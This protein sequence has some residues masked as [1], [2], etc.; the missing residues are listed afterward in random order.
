MRNHSDVLVVGGGVIGAACAYYL[1]REGKYVRIIEQDKIGSGASHGNCG[2]IF[3]SHLFPLC[4]PGAIADAVKNMFSRSSP[5]Y[6]KPVPDLQRLIW[7]LNF[8]GKCTPGHL[9]HAVGARLRMLRLSEALYAD[10]FETEKIDCDYEQRGILVVFKSEAAMQEYTRINDYLKQF[11][12]EARPFLGD[13]LLQLE[14]ALRDDVYGGWYHAIDSHLRPDHFLREFKQVLIQKGVAVEENCRLLNLHSDVGMITKAETSSGIYTADAYVMAAGAWTPEIFRKLKLK[15]PIQPGKGYSIT[16]A[17][18]ALCP[19]IP[20]IFE[21][22]SVVATPWE[23]GYRLGG[24]ME[25]SGLNTRLVTKRIQ[26]LKDG[27]REYLKEPIGEPVHEEWVGMRPMVYDDLPV[28]D[29]APGQR[30]LLLAAGHGMMGISLA[31]ATGKLI[32]DLVVGRD[33]HIDISPFNI[34]RFQ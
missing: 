9:K 14:P 5:L 11:G 30:N 25:F 28:I 2:L 10:F 1:A 15:L 34:M 33:P 29:R 23:S 26:N 3:I 12:M 24:T 16:M 7:F 18:P 6:I 27:A 22:K 20:C 4:A 32:A 17:R 21:E 13:A 8:A 31:P 19:K